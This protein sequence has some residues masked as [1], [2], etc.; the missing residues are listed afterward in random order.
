MKNLLIDINALPENDQ[1]EGI[2]KTLRDV[3]SLVKEFSVPLTAEQRK[4]LRKMGARR[5][6]YAQAALRH[7]SEH[8]NLLPRNEDVAPFDT[9]SQYYAKIIVLRDLANSLNELID[10]TVKAIGIDM[11]RYTKLAHD[12]FKSG[13]ERDPQYDDILKELDDFNKRASSE[14]A[15]PYMEN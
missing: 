2:R 13:N 12:S 9:I 15:E 10:D 11:M 6:A 8:E 7:I 1:I 3:T 14:E 4:S 5:L